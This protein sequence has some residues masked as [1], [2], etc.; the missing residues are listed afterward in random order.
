VT[1]LL[2][3]IASGL[4]GL[5]VAMN[6][7]HY[8]RPGLLLVF[9][10]LALLITTLRAPWP[11]AVEQ[12][13][14]AYLGQAL[15]AVVAV[16]FVA[17]AV[18]RPC[19][20]MSPDTSLAGFR[21]GIILAALLTLTY[22]GPRGL[23]PRLRFPLILAVFLA[24]GVWTIRA[25]P[26]PHID[27]W[28]AQQRA[29]ELLLGGQNP[30]TAYYPNIY[31]DLRYFGWG[32]LKDGRLYSITY[33]PLVVLLGVPGWLLL[34]DV[35]LS[36]LAA[37]AG[38]AAV[39][40]AT[41]RRMGLPAGHVAELAAVALLFHPRA[42]FLIEQA[43][44]DPYMALGAAAVLWALA[45]ERGRALRILLAL[46]LNA[47]QHAF[48]WLPLLV[49]PRRLRWRDAL[50]AGALGAIVVLPFF[51]WS[52]E[53]FWRGVFLIQLTNPFRTDALSA[54]TA[55]AR[56]T[57]IHLPSIVGF[58]AAGL[59]TAYAIRRRRHMPGQEALGGAVMYLAFFAFNKQAFLNYYW[60]VGAF[61]MLATTA[62]AAG[63][64]EGAGESRAR[65]Q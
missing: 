26:S 34:G 61:L 14:R 43:W 12:A 4:L 7:G 41:G 39:A 52:P 64:C 65:A 19:I 63:P 48:L 58:A 59:V 5:A 45:S 35:R 46:Y 62:L 53:G 47:K 1:P 56:A 10:A 30:Y 49:A 11:D 22:A 2:A 27:V 9:A 18:L 51:A 17:L 31:G 44:V 50:A 37:V 25:V 33:P 32:S 23:A 13:G 15:G 38:A 42:F 8:S 29:V 57:G 54:L 24:L 21:A 16:G 40:V 55:V 28:H 20:Y 3:V 6:N 60:L 36:L